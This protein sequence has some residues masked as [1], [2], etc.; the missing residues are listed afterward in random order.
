MPSE[1]IKPKAFVFLF[2]GLCAH[3]NHGAHVAK[4]LAKIGCIVVGF[5]Y[6]GMKIE[7]TFRLRKE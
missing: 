2:H 7:I 5:D 4:E 6:R 1:E 3:M